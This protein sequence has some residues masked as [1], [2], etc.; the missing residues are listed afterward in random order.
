MFDHIDRSPRN[1]HATS[2][3]LRQLAQSSRSNLVVQASSLPGVWRPLSLGT[4]AGIESL[5]LGKL[6]A[7]TTKIS[8]ERPSDGD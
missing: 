4:L 1:L 7:C 5:S 3:P 8:S 2:L 6:E